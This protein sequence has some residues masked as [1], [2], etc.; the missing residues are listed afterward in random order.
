[1]ACSDISTGGTQAL[2][3]ERPTG[4]S[5]LSSWANKEQHWVKVEC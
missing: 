1:V 3:L 5:P 2:Q 4:F